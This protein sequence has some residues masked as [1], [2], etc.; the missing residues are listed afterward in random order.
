MSKKDT[1]NRLWNQSMYDYDHLSANL[2][3]FYDASRADLEK[4]IAELRLQCISDFG[5]YVDGTDAMAKRLSE[6]EK[7]IAMAKEALVPYMKL[8]D[9]TKVKNRAAQTY[10]AIEEWEKK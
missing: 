3:R 10:D 1:I 6:A 9:G 2:E 7:V 5:Q 4:E 8:V